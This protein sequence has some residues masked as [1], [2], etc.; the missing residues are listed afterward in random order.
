M[1]MSTEAQQAAPSVPESSSQELESKE[2]SLVLPVKKR[3]I[4]GVQPTGN[5]H[6]GNYLGAVQQ[7]VTNQVRVKQLL[8]GVK[9]AVDGY[10]SSTAK[11]DMRVYSGDSRQTV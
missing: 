1:R 10:D 11:G 2:S 6:L 4:S 5:L 9:R 8:R 7:W 3:V